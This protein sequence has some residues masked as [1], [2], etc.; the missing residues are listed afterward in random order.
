MDQKRYCFREKTMNSIV[1]ARS[2]VR[3]IK[4]RC[5]NLSDEKEAIS[6]FNDVSRIDDVYTASRVGHALRALSMEDFG[7]TPVLPVKDL[8]I[9][10]LSNFTVTNLESFL[11]LEMIK[12]RII[13][14]LYVADFDQVAAELMNEQSHTHHMKPDMTLCVLDEHI[15]TDRLGSKIVSSEINDVIHECL[16][17][18]TTLWTHFSSNNRGILVLNTLP[19][20]ESLLSTIID[21]R[22]KARVASAWHRF[23]SRVLELS[24][25]H[26]NIVVIDVNPMLQSRDVCLRDERMALYAKMYFDDSLLWMLAKEYRKIAQSLVGHTK[27]CLVLDCDNTLWGGVVGDDGLEG[28]VLGNSPEGEAFASLQKTILAL[29][30]QGVLL[31]LASKNDQ[32]NTD[33]VFNKHPDAALSLDDFSA[34]YVDWSPKT[35]NIHS[36]AKALNVGIDHCVFFDDSAFECELMR[37]TLPQ[38]QTLHMPE[39]AAD[40]RHALL[41]GGY[42]NLL[43]V[44]QADLERKD[45]Y[46]LDKKRDALKSSLVS[47]DDYLKN[48]GIKLTIFQPGSLDIPRI[49][50]ITQK[51]NQ[52]N[53]TTWR[54]TEADVLERVKDKDW[55]VI[56]VQSED[57]F[58]SNGIVGAVFVERVTA[59]EAVIR[60]FLLSCRVF[61][62]GIE[63]RVLFA[64]VEMLAR[65]GINHI[66]GLYEESAKNKNFSDFY[67]RNNFR[68]DTETGRFIATMDVSIQIPAP[69][70]DFS[71]NYDGEHDVNV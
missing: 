36:I 19:L 57:R 35:E 18:F 12:N 46:N 27:K 30:K 42:F 68:A 20:P 41:S 50:Q 48:L 60:N 28:I 34:Q 39:D 25:K 4:A 16:E 7:D 2:F 37:Q 44:T 17:E 51:T 10:V 32:S 49:A 52:F 1:N 66:V 71:N 69:W 61:S 13:P 24:E 14:N 29:S 58:G 23:N 3:H 59:H 11:S 63:E 56:A 21:Y 43:N 15:I 5:E 6:F 67:S 53:L 45:Y 65:A 64:V 38:V 62:R 47:Y 26:H 22:S 55:Y 8:K 40:A 31:A 54:M 33:E 70:I 9:A